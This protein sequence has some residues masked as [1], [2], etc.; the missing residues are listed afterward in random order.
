MIYRYRLVKAS[1]LIQIQL[2]SVLY[3]KEWKYTTSPLEIENFEGLIEEQKAETREEFQEENLFEEI[4]QVETKP[5]KIS[6]KPVQPQ[7]NVIQ[8]EG[9]LEK[10]ETDPIKMDDTQLVRFLVKAG[11]SET[12]LQKLSREQLLQLADIETGS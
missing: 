5:K 12:D 3:T 2:N 1:E 6:S 4:R 11:H 8:E 9:S 10:E 7:E